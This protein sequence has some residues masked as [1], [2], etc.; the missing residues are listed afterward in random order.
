MMGT[1]EML[2]DREGSSLLI[3]VASTSYVSAI[4]SKLTLFDMDLA[5][6]LASEC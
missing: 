3:G 6:S 4:F 1:K 5:S 2:S